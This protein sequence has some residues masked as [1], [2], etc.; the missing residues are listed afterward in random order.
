MIMVYKFGFCCL[1]STL[2]AGLLSGCTNVE[3]WER[4]ILAK[5]HMTLIP[6][7]L[8][9]EFINHVYS[10]REGTEGATGTVGGGC[11]CN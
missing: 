2:T 1:L 6:D 8:G 11:G 4:N 3:P 5:D 7:P 9:A 10:S